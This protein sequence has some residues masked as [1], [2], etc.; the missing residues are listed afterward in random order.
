MLYLQ[1]NLFSS[2]STFFPLFLLIPQ[3]P[4]I[5]SVLRKAGKS[6]ARNDNVSK[7]P[8]GSSETGG[9]S[10]STSPTT[11]ASAGLVSSTNFAKR[12]EVLFCGRVTVP[13]KNAPPALIDECIVKFSQLRNSGESVTEGD[14]LGL[15]DGLKTFVVPANGLKSRDVDDGSTGS[16]TTGKHPVLFK[17]APSFPSLQ[18]LDENGLSP[19]IC[20]VIT[21]ESHLHLTGVQPTSQQENSNMLFMVML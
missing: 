10:L 14:P 3:V 2:G 13:H 6:S 12:F 16:P 18:A 15:R 8:S 21:T 11:V 1:I 17:R 7:L 19:E 4:E 9:S 5:I 20:Q